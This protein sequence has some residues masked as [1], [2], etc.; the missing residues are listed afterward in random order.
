MRTAVLASGALSGP[1]G[2]SDAS[3]V[4]AAGCGRKQ[5][6]LRARSRTVR[7]STPRRAS[8]VATT[9][10]NHRGAMP[11]GTTATPSTR[12]MSN[13]RSTSD[14][15]LVQPLL[16]SRLPV[17]MRRRGWS[18]A[19][20]VPHQLG[21]GGWKLST[22]NAR[23]PRGQPANATPMG[24]A[25]AS[26]PATMST[27]SRAPPQYP[28]I[29]RFGLVR[30]CSSAGNTPPATSWAPLQ[31]GVVHHRHHTVEISGIWSLNP[32]ATRTWPMQLGPAD[33]D[34][35]MVSC[36]RSGWPTRRAPFHHD[37]KRPAS[38]TAIVS[39]MVGSAVPPRPCTRKPPKV[40]TLA[41][42]AD[43]CHHGMPAVRQAI[44]S[45]TRH[46]LGA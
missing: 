34:V 36:R 30:N 1:A 19:Y 4:G 7:R 8:W 44:C 28:R 37:G 22:S 17:M 29:G 2:A 33:P 6:W 38:A 18:M 13:L 5:I 21:C 35:G 14:G 11:L 39:A 10:A 24:P 45:A 31:H 43:V 32:A 9:D 20:R 46:R 41:G 40:L 26:A 25:G 3:G 16:A 15:A 12:S 27:A 42:E 23:S